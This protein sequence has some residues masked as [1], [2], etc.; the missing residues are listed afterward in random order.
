[1]A[2]FL[3]LVF[4]LAGHTPSHLLR[5]G[6][7]TDITFQVVLS[8]LYAAH[9]LGH[10]PQSVETSLQTAITTPNQW[11]ADATPSSTGVPSPIP[12]SSFLDSTTATDTVTSPSTKTTGSVI[13]MTS[14]TAV[15]STSAVATPT[16]IS[17]RIMALGASITYGE[18]SSDGN[19]Y[20]QYLRN[21][22]IA[23]GSWNSID[24]VGSQKHGSM[25]DNDAEGWPG[26]GVD[27]VHSK[28]STSVPRFLPNIVLLNVGANDCINGL[29]S[30]GIGDRMR[31]FVNDLFK[32]SPGVTVLLSSLLLN[33][34]PAT[35]GCVLKANAQYQSLAVSLRAAG[36]RVVFVDMHSGQGPLASDM[37]DV[38]HPNDK[39]YEKM[40]NLW[41]AG[42]AVASSAGFIQPPQ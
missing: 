31:S 18:L 12:S 23:N 28:V 30:N 24:M 38:T 42:L 39:G 33:L 37:A 2:F 41:F 29:N 27:N 22:L 32:W 34:D 26:F 14:R 6:I 11:P 7:S 15:A 35:E 4:L 19:G 10:V 40:A 9:V 36:Q 8:A 17:L 16:R 1:M 5:H 13:I 20:R 25:A 3:F 21:A